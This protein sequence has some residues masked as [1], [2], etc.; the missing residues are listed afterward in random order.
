MGAV[1]LVECAMKYLKLTIRWAV[2]YPLLIASHAL[3][4]VVLAIVHIVALIAF[5]IDDWLE[6]E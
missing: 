6:G 5:Y 2:V 4:Y 1:V 3:L